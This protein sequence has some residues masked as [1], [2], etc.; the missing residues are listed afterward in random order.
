M[1]LIK[2]WFKRGFILPATVV[3][4]LSVP[5]STAQAAF[6][7]YSFTGIL[8]NNPPGVSPISGSFQ[9]D[10]ATGGSGGVYNGAVTGFTL[11][12][13]G[14]YTSSFKLGANAVTISQNITLGGGNGDRWELASAATGPNPNGFTAYDFDLRL[15]RVGGGLFTNT[16]LQN[17]PS[18]NGLNGVTGRWRLFFEDA[19]GNPFV[20][21]GSISNLAPVPLPAA[22]LLF[23]A[24]L[25]SLVGLGAGR[26]RNLRGAKA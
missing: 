7:N 19:A 13:V 16:D 2:E 8:E 25:I 11:N 15:D 5:I 21:L 26:L 18:V 14:L 6:V 4:A 22:V 23:G 17:P 10:N 12:L 1:Q 24:G 9:F 20:F 3:C